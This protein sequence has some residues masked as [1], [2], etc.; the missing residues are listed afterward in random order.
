MDSGPAQT[1]LICKTGTVAEIDGYRRL[2]RV[3][4]EVKP[5]RTGGR[6]GVCPCC[7]AV[8]KIFDDTTRPDI[9][10]IYANYDLYPLS[11]GVEQPIFDMSGRPLLRS[12]RIFRYLK[13]QVVL[14]ETAAL[15]DF[16]CGR[17][18][19]LT[20]ASR[21]FPKWRL[22]GSELSNR[23]LDLLRKIPGFVKLFVGD[24]ADI[25][26]RFDIVTMI[27]SL[28]HIFDPVE[29]LRILA[30]KLVP[31]GKIVIQVPDGGA[32][33]Y[34]MMIADH[35]S[36][37]TGDTLTLVAAM[38]GLAST[39]TSTEVA[40]KELTWV[41]QPNPRI[42]VEVGSGG[43]RRLGE[44]EADIRWLQEQADM[45]GRISGAATKFG[46]FGTAT[47]GTWLAGEL[48]GRFDFFVD[49]DTMRHGK[50]HVDRPVI[51][52]ADIPDGADVFLP[53]IDKS[54]RA[55]AARLGQ[56]FPKVHF[57]VPPSR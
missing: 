16:G 37:F 25:S 54:A 52:P 3:T 29:M 2:R 31:G 6:I 43:S 30:T 22:F 47:S 45:A 26:D 49:E 42:K 41:L 40:A 55:V 14:P 51:G 27:H 46:I 17:G 20:E 11:D 1:C 19:T 36:H 10:A 38:A 7:G 34:D 28:E 5:F 8:Q 21:F 4:S 9:D 39:A 44:I 50:I 15:L 57:H 23:S 12:T 53:L 13:D 56:A 18:A 33:P 48:D 24:V 32:N 35:V